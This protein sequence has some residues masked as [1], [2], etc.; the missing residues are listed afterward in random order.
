MK[1]KKRYKKKHN[2]ESFKILSFFSL[3][4]PLIQIFIVGVICDIIAYN[5]DKRI[6]PKRKK[7]EKEIYQLK[8]VSLEYNPHTRTIALNYKIPFSK[9]SK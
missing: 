1:Y 5:H 8:K 6:I 4:N 7:L 3:N 9:L 2:I